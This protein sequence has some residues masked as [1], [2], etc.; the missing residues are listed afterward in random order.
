MR[1]I[2]TI[3][4]FIIIS[5]GSSPQK[6]E[7]IVNKTVK[8]FSE[9]FH[10]QAENYTFKWQPP[11]DPNNN[12]TIFDLKSDMLIFTPKKIGTYKVSLSIEDIAGEIVAKE[13]FLFNAI[14]ETTRVALLNSEEKPIDVSNLQHEKYSNKKT[15]E[16]KQKATD[17][18][19]KVEKKIIPRKKTIKKTGLNYEYAIQIS[20]WPSL[21][22]ARKH[23]LELI[24][25]GFDAYTQRFYSKNNDAIWY[26]VRMGKFLTKKKAQKIKKQVEDATGI[27]TWLDILSSK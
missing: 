18:K 26:R 9:K 21:E 6:K 10:N 14:Q 12:K 15:S 5:C 16:E 19:I 4:F 8:V 27:I 24:E 17:E 13:I 22:E 2:F 23:Q 11:I 3:L 25:L 1:K 7:V 20:S